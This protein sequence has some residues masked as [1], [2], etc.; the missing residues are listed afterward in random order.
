MFRRPSLLAFLLLA[1]A[2]P[3][4]AQASPDAPAP[5]AGSLV[6]VPVAPVVPAS[7]ADTLGVA[8]VASPVVVPVPIGPVGVTRRQAAPAEVQAFQSQA[9]LG[10]AR[11]MMI[12]GAGAL[13]A[14]AI[15]DGD[16]GT[17]IM[18]GGAIIGLYG[19]YKYLQ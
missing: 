12:V 8:P 18:V 17:I 10:Q 13:L 4:L 2:A 6:A 19:L 5:A 15:I 14:G 1:T 9:G 7:P 3:L 16:A 11:A